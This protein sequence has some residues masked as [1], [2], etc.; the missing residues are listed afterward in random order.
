MSS[1]FLCLSKDD[2]D[3]TNYLQTVDNFIQELQLI[4]T[5]I[6][7]P[8]TKEIVKNSFKAVVDV[9]SIYKNPLINLVLKDFAIFQAKKVLSDSDEIIQNIRN[10]QERVRG[11]VQERVQGSVQERVQERVN[12]STINIVKSEDI[13]IDSDFSDDEFLRDEKNE[14]IKNS[15]NNIIKNSSIHTFFIIKKNE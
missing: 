1:N 14:M 3:E 13:I 12:Q 10:V 5:Q 15:F 11:S 2:I 9:I 8:E 4:R 6:V 7:Q